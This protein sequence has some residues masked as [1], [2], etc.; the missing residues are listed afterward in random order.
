MGLDDREHRS[1]RPRQVSATMR[2]E[3]EHEVP[4]ELRQKLG[5]GDGD[6]AQGC[7]AS[8]VQ[9]DQEVD[10]VPCRVSGKAVVGL[11]RGAHGNADFPG[12]L[13]RLDHDGGVPDLVGFARRRVV[14]VH[15]ADEG[16]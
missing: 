5:A 7:S 1:V 16:S 4:L 2:A 3:A 11:G 13:K 12:P 9:E 6:A 10:G 14:A 8:V 15:S